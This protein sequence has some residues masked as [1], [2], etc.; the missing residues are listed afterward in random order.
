MRLFLI[1]GGAVPIYEYIYRK[2]GWEGVL[3]KPPHKRM[4]ICPEC[5][6]PVPPRISTTTRRWGKGGEPS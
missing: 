1:E 4:H 6:E 5:K 3:I 2:C